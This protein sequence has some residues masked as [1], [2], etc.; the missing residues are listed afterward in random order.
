[1]TAALSDDLLAAMTA[2]VPL[3][4]VAEYPQ[5]DRRCRTVSRLFRRLVH[6]RRRH[7]RGWR[8]GYGT[9]TRVLQLWNHLQ[10]E[11]CGPSTVCPLS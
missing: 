11:N 6:H 8:V 4:L 10:G 9:L 2:A 1:M 3:G 5:G 7:P